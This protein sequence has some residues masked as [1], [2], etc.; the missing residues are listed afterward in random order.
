MIGIDS[1]L[2]RIIDSSVPEKPLVPIDKFMTTNISDSNKK[3][4]SRD[5]TS[6]VNKIEGRKDM[7]TT[8]GQRR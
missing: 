4:D 5:Q 8:D 3:H 2:T 1:V 6:A 7:P